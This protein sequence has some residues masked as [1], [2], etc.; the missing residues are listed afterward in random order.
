[1]DRKDTFSLGV[2]NGCQ[3]MVKL[4]L[5][6][7]ELT[8]IENNSGKFESRFS[9]VK[10]VDDNNIF[11]KDMKNMRFGIWIAHKE[12]KFV[13][14]QNL[15]K[16]QKVLKYVHPNINEHKTQYPYNPNGSHEDIAGVCSENGRHLAMMPH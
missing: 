4:N 12:G 16:T 15:N 13:S 8:I 2:C 5:F 1:M 6:N 14:T 7:D 3:L 11:F 9:L 10:I